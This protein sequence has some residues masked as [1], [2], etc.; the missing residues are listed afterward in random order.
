ME[1][2]AVEK[3]NSR[4]KLGGERKSEH[5]PVPSSGRASAGRRRLTGRDRTSN[6]PQG[7]TWADGNHST[8]I[9]VS[10]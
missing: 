9:Q 1:S 6:S 3:H 7:P 4:K 2:I 8:S 10:K 5:K